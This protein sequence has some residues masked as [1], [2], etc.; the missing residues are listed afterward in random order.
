M[1]KKILIVDDEL[2]PRESL[3][4]ILGPLYELDMA[5][6]GIEAL[7]KLKESSYDLIITDTRMPCMCGDEMISIIRKD[8]DMNV[9]IIVFDAG[10]IHE[11]YHTML[12][13][14]LISA[15]IPKPYSLQE[16]MS[17]IE[18]ELLLSN[19]FRNC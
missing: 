3:R 6:D 17:T 19:V 14:G 4:L 15:C 7:N 18:I 16:V 2:G 13:K 1:K 9:P 10:N 5:E 11:P 12:K 8:I